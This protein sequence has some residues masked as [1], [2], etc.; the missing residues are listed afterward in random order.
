ML[1]SQNPPV[2]APF[3][4][5]GMS[6]FSRYT[7]TFSDLSST[8]VTTVHDRKLQL[9]LFDLDKFMFPVNVNGNHWTLAVIN[10]RLERLEYYDSLGAPFGDDGFEVLDISCPF[11]LC[12]AIGGGLPLCLP[13]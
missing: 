2:S 13:C 3:I 12:V 5:F 1:R 11:F 6:G 7:A 8:F 9:D 10:F 4:T